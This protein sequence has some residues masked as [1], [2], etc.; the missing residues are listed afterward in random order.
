[1]LR[2]CISMLLIMIISGCAIKDAQDA[3]DSQRQI[4]DPPKENVLACLD[5]PV[6]GQKCGLSLPRPVLP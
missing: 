1:M 5:L 2:V 3:A 4:S 6:A